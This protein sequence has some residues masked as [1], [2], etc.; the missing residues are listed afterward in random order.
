MTNPQSLPQSHQKEY[1]QHTGV[2]L[3]WS[4]DCP[5]RALVWV[6]QPLRLCWRL[7]AVLLW[8]SGQQLKVKKACLRSLSWEETKCMA[9]C[10]LMH[11]HPLKYA[12]GGIFK[13]NFLCFRIPR[14]PWGHH[15]F[16]FFVIIIVLWCPRITKFKFKGYF[17]MWLRIPWVCTK[18]VEWNRHTLH[19]LILH[20]RD[21]FKAWRRHIPVLVYLFLPCSP[22]RITVGQQHIRLVLQVETE[23][24][25]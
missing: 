8:G 22:W 9:P 15:C 24:N 4:S 16:S 12:L 7:P 1:C 3:A 13:S 25:R 19:G 23:R 11:T 14:Q 5:Q 17:Q 18:H 6:W 20:G 2:G 10:H 21:V